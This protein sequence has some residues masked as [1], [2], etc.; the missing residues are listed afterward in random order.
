MD[1]TLVPEP[2]EIYKRARDKQPSV[3][4]DGYVPSTKEFSTARAEFALR[5]HA[6]IV[7]SRGVGAKDSWVVSRWGHSRPFDNWT[8][9]LEFLAQIG[10]QP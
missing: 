5:G 1:A 6:L 10:G 9:V 8:D 2:A 4:S 3:A 7:S